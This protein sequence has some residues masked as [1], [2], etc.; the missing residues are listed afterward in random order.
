MGSDVT[1]AAAGRREMVPGSRSAL[2]ES[3]ARAL[4]RRDL[5]PLAADETLRLR[6]RFRA[7]RDEAGKNPDADRVLETST[8]DALVVESLLGWLAARLPARLTLLLVA[9]RGSEVRAVGGLTARAL[10]HVQEMVQEPGDAIQI[11]SADLGFGLALDVAEP[12]P[13][14]RSRLFRLFV[15]GSPR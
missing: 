2:L 8:P 5:A 14:A 4:E 7:R 9:T 3:L 15:W 11:V 12:G 6:E 1:R 13:G 10:L